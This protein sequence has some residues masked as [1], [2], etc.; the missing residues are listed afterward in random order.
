MDNQKT[1]KFI[2]ECR[3]K[4]GY[5]QKELAEKLN[6]TDKAVSKW[7]TGRSSPDVS[8]LMPLS[9]M[10]NVSVAEILNGEKISQEEIST[11]SNEI[12]VKSLKKSKSRILLAIILVLVL[13]I[14]IFLS[15]PIYQY[16]NSISVNDDYAVKALFRDKLDIENIFQYPC[17]KYAVKG[18]YTAYLYHDD[19]KAYMLLFEENELFNSRMNF[20]GGTAA[21]ISE[22]GLYSTCESGKNINIFFGAEIVAKKYAYIYDDVKHIVTIDDDDFINIFI[23]ENDV[24]INP[25]D[26]YF[27]EE[28]EP[29]QSTH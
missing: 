29:D 15:Y 7:E 17:S 22:I 18:K 28:Q 11:V 20:V 8:L 16:A 27:T 6:I 13:L 23:D 1:G 24:M 12:I 2:A 14:G 26:W 4:S 21:K 10:L 5:N 3:K 9:E 25:A 19:E